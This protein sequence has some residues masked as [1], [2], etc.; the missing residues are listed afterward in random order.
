MVPF[1]ML[2]FGTFLKWYHFYLCFLVLF[3]NGTIFVAEF[4]QIPQL[5]PFLFQNF[6]TFLKWY[7][8]LSDFLHFAQMV[9]YFGFQKFSYCTRMVPFLLLKL[10]LNGTICV[11]DF[12]LPN[13][14]TFLNWYL[15]CYKIFALFSN[16]S[17]FVL[18]FIALCSNR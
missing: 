2:N 13:F 12:L 9:P 3:S 11:C 8:F 16:G 7:H 10:F 5:V 4:S 17:I 15:I 18:F 6:R 14:R 1:L